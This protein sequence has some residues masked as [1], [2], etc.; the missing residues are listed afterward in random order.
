ML[1]SAIPP[2][3]IFS[4]AMT[5]QM[6]MCIALAAGLAALLQGLSGFG[7]SL[8][9]GSVLMSLR[10]ELGL[11]LPTIVLL[12]NV[13]TLFCQAVIMYRLRGQAALR[14]VWSLLVGAALMIPVG[15]WLLTTFGRQPWL[16]RVFGLFVSSVAIWLMVAPKRPSVTPSHRRLLGFAAGLL[17]GL[18]NG[19]FNAGGPPAV[20]YTYTR[21]IPLNS[22]KATVQWIFTGASLYRLTLVALLL[23]F[24]GLGDEGRPDLVVVGFGLFSVPL[25]VVASLAGMSLAGR[26][27]PDRLRTAVFLLL[28]V[29]G[30]RATIWP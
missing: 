12:A 25:V 17:T 30:L 9:F 13:T 15:V 14:A 5:I 19:M 8:L 3:D 28:I 21:P 26:V 22:A 20:L 7:Y 10:H 11:S 24:G 6:F 16:V 4:C 1:F 23:I 27:H 18:G 29:F 2:V